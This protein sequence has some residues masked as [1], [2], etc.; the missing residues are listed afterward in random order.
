MASCSSAVHARSINDAVI[1]MEDRGKYPAEMDKKYPNRAYARLSAQPDSCT[2]E[3]Y[4][5]QLGK[6]CKI[7]TGVKSSVLTK[8]TACS[9]LTMD[10]QNFMHRDYHDSICNGGLI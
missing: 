7:I 3:I 1:K 4:E 9:A 6:N 8:G 10:A 5:C 2:G